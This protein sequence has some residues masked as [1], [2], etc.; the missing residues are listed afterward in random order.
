[1]PFDKIIG[2]E[3]HSNINQKQ[4]YN[5]NGYPGLLWLVIAT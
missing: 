3:K 4:E 1:M 2:I 5:R